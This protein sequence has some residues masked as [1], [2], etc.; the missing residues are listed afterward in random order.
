M[1]GPYQFPRGL[2]QVI[3]RG[4]LEKKAERGL[5]KEGAEQ[6]GL[7]SKRRSSLVMRDFY[8]TGLLG[9][10]LIFLSFFKG[11]GSL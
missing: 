1:G 11:G 8:T 3:T 5:I 6:G 10:G 7:H 4:S 9:R 2:L